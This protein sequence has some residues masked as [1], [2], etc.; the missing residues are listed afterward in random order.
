MTTIRDFGWWYWAVT[1]VLLMTGLA[2]HSIG[3]WLAILL[4]AIQLLHVASLTH[5]LT[6]LPVQ[7][8]A[9]YLAILIAGLWEPLEWIHWMQLAATT[10]RVL[11]GYC[12]L[13]R[14]LSLAPWNRWQPLTLAL[15]RRTYLSIQ[16]AV[17]SCG[18][19]FRRMSFERVQG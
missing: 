13:S 2:G 3:I 8:R 19:V 17:P 4:Y 9:A 12:F 6:A 14:T 7:V 15:V 5:D 1:A 16:T 18:D 10:A 11:A